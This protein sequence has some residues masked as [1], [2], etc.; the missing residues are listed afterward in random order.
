MHL[1]QRKC[2]IG[3]GIAAKLDQLLCCYFI[4]EVSKTFAYK[5]TF[6]LNARVFI[7]V[8]IHAKIVFIKQQENLFASF[9]AEV[10]IF[11]GNQFLIAGL[12]AM[13]AFG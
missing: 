11:Y 12:A 6:G 8:I 2:Y 7:Q 1:R 13:I 9:A 10:L 3:L 5:F 4:I